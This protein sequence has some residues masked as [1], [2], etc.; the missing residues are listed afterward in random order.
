M[1]RLTRLSNSPLLSAESLTA[2]IKNTLGGLGTLGRARRSTDVEA[3]CRQRPSE[4]SRAKEM[5][6]PAEVATRDG[7]GDSGCG[8]EGN[9]VGASRKRSNA[10]V[11]DDKEMVA[12]GRSVRDTVQTMRG[13]A[14]LYPLSLSL[15]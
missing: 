2:A 7:I 12:L 6:M 1:D 15:R 11:K 10:I 5:A 4:S 9:W 8:E 3:E 14:E 13:L